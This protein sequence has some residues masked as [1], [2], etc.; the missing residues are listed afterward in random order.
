[1]GKRNQI[2]LR[3]RKNRNLNG[4]VRITPE[5]EAIVLD[6]ADRSGLSVCQVVSQMIIQGSEF[7]HLADE[8]SVID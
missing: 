8:E 1:M 3:G 2:I 7:T 4:V 6:L 5:A